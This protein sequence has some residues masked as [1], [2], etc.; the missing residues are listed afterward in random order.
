M[1]EPI[2]ELA[3]EAAELVSKHGSI[4]AAARAAGVARTTMQ[5]R[6]HAAARM[7]LL[8]TKPVLPGFRLSKTTTV[9]NQDGDVVR[10]FIQQRPELGSEFA[11]PSG[12]TV[13]GVSALVDANGHTIQQW[14]KTKGSGPDP[15]RIADILKKSF[16]D[17]KPAAKPVR[18]PSYSAADLLSFLACNDWHIGMFSWHRD[19]GK[20][21]DLKIAEKTIGDVVE[22]TIEQS[23][24]CGTCVVLGGGDLIHAD[25]KHNQTTGGTPQDVD[26]RYEKIIEVASRMKVRTV[27]AALRR[28]KK[29]IVRILKGNHDEHAS[30]AVAHFLKAWY[31]NEPRVIVDTDASA[32][33]KYRFGLVMLAAAHGHTVKIKNMPQIMAHRYAED[34]GAT[35]FRYAHGFHLHH[36]ELIAIEGGGCICEVHQAP[37]PQD[38]WHYGKGYLSGAGIQ[39]ITYHKQLGERGRVVNGII[40]ADNKRAA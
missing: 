34:W 36:K 35:K 2:A 6:V 28:H 9:T 11:V 15:E 17:Y 7:G 40:H 26:G 23:P 20:N 27:D 12:H 1:H 18:A 31:R 24:A 3:Q 5:H 13:K 10:E 21:W 16:E 19:T 32:Y 39:S 38:S 22:Q 30:V 8:G 25:N 29:V 14:V 37:I 33:W 4:S